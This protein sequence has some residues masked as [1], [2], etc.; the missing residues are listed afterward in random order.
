MM[1]LTIDSMSG[2]DS[3]LYELIYRSDQVEDIRSYR[4][5]KD[6]AVSGRY[7]LDERNSIVLWITNTGDG[8]YSVF[9]LDSIMIV[10]TLL[11]HDT[12]LQSIIITYN[13]NSYSSTGGLDELPVVES[14]D[15]FSIQESH[16]FRK[17]QKGVE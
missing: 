16:L 1:Q 14:Y 2:S 6:T 8:L 4:L 13:H 5:I 15:I 12:S 11:H 3:L 7:I 17:K 10:T 9:S